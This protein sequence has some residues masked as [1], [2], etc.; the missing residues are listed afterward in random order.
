MSSHDDLLMASAG[1][2]DN[3]FVIEEKK[4]RETKKNKQRHGRWWMTLTFKR[5]IIYKR[6]NQLPVNVN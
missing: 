3:V 6:V 2:C 4:P 1:F 5:R